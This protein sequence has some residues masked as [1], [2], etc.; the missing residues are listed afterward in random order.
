ML[1][2]IRVSLY[3]PIWLYSNWDKVRLSSSATSFTFQ[4]GYIQMIAGTIFPAFRVIFTFQSGYIQIYIA[5]S[6]INSS[7]VFTFQSGYIQMKALQVLATN[8]NL[9]Y[10]P[11][12]LYSNS[13]WLVCRAWHELFTFQSGYIQISLPTHR[14]S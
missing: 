9:L 8:N 10:I 11:I 1:S 12:W 13:A 6:R 2:V 14:V 4:S 5:S 7:F 3:I